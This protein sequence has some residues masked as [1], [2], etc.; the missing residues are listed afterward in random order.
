MLRLLRGLRRRIQALQALRH[1]RRDTFARLAAAPVRRVLVV[2]YG[3]IYRSP[4]AAEYLRAHAPGI[5]VRSVGFHQKSGRPSPPEHVQAAAARG[6]ALEAHRSSR[7]TSE[8]LS[9]AD[10]I[11]LMDRHNFTQLAALGAD[12]AKLVWLGVLAGDHPEIDDPYRRDAAGAA[13]LMDQLER[14]AAA[15]AAAIKRES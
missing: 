12:R 7:V 8:D 15:L 2:C 3:N 14:G 5:E 11:V 13:R 4:F 10:T 1:A 6:V 9:W